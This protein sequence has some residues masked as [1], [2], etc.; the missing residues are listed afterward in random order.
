MADL[1]KLQRS[2][3]LK[4]RDQGIL[5]K[6]LTHGSYIHEN[7]DA[8]QESNQ[9]LEFLGD[10]VLGHV[11]AQELYQRYPSLDEGQLT[12][13]RAQMVRT[14]TLSAVAHRLGIGGYLY[15]GKGEEGSGGESKPRNLAGALEALIGA[16]LLDRGMEAAR[17][18]ILEQLEEEMERAGASGQ[19]KDYKSQLQHLS[20]ARWKVQPTYTTEEEETSP[21]PRV[22]VAHAVVDGRTLGQGTGLAKQA[23]QMEAA[24]D[25]LERMSA[26]EGTG[27]A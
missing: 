16:I 15:F 24:R 11:V 5:R 26:L 18:F 8:A 14:E 3:G 6:A 21:D 10:A 4:F 9:R 19:V 13:A 25:A 20:Q 7:P 1:T 27:E 2:L 22:F 12:E 17:R 23:A